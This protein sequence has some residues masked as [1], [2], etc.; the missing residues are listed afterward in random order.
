MMGDLIV[1]QKVCKCCILEIILKDQNPHTHGVCDLRFF[2]L[3]SDSKIIFLLFL[4]LFGR[5]EGVI[6]EIKGER[7]VF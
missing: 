5:L 2:A 1:F 7:Q 4:H 3:E 6:K